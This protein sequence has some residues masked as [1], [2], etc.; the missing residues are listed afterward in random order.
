MTAPTAAAL[1]DGQYLSLTTYKKDGTAVPTAVWVCRDGE[2][3]YAM[4][5]S[6]AWKAKRIAVNGEVL[7]ASC[8]AKGT[9]KTEQVKGTAA[10][11]D[12][13]GTEDVKRRMG[14]K[15]GQ[16]RV[17]AFAWIGRRV[18]KAP[19]QVGIRITLAE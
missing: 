14:D 18:R 16:V 4:T 2:T 19:G 7:V 5:Q 17:K 6:N 13:A 1:G 12:D 8:D 11:L 10:L 9:L 15:Y 3:I